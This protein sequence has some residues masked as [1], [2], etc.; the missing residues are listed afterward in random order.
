[1]NFKLDA[2]VDVNYRDPENNYSAFLICKLLFNTRI[3]RRELIHICA[4]VWKRNSMPMLQYLKSKGADLNARN[5][6]LINT[7]FLN[8]FSL[9][10]PFAVY[11]QFFLKLNFV[12]LSV[13]D[14]QQLFLFLFVIICSGEKAR[15]TWLVT[16]RIWKF[17][18]G[19]WK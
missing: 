3:A 16:A 11:L 2:D 14:K 17:S 5:K 15:F 18:S 6:V 12:H 13:N 4:A 7:F 19:S 1:V 9:P 10:P 8:N